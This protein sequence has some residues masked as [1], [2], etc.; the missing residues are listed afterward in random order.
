MESLEK[1]DLYKNTNVLIS[2]LSRTTPCWFAAIVSG[3]RFKYPLHLRML[4][5]VLIDASQR[6]IKKIII[7]M[8]PRHGKS[9]LISKY[10]PVW[11]LGTFPN[12]RIILASY[13]ATFAA[14]WGRKIRNIIK[15]HGEHYFGIKLDPK[16]S[17]TMRFDLSEYEGG[18]NTAGTG[19]PITGKGADLLI[20]DDPVKNDAEANSQ[21]LRDNLWDWFNTTAYT[22]LEPDGIIIIVMTRWHEDDLCGRILQ[23]ESKHQD[24]DLDTDKWYVF[25][26]P[27]LAE[28]NDALK[29]LPGEPL[30]RE[31]FSAKK[32]K[33]IKNTQG[34]YWF[35]AMYQQRPVPRGD[36]IF[37]RKYFRYFR[38]DEEFY[39]TSNSIG[40]VQHEKVIKR[41][42]CTIYSIIDLACSTKETA[43]YT[44]IL[45]C[46]VSPDN[47]V[48]IIDVIRERFSGADH[49]N[50]INKV[51]ER[52]HPVMIGIESN[53]FQITIIQNA[54]DSGYNVQELIADKDKLTRAL[55]MAARLEAGTVYF[56]AD[57]HWLDDFEAELLAFPNGRHDD[58]VDA[59]AY[60]A[61]F[62]QIKSGILPA[63]AGVS[64]TMK[65]SI[66]SGF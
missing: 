64:R 39:Y 31:R 19:G 27:A 14:S 55:P 48:F 29:R 24:D 11:Y 7:N 59:F 33:D 37:K 25:S 63:G 4:D 13:E 17:A 20:I 12:H 34:S 52:F 53:Q 60:I 57:A 61:V 42:D 50:Q 41:S 40:T 62:I 36:G 38:Q 2:A 30:W 9:E 1:T 46:A 26:L 44:V 10:F 54:R 8:P 47:N 18:L 35:S 43:D 23:N 65:N 5:K 6:K 56:L 49:L 51:N 58:Q 28:E 22:R 3:G 32:L 45:T 16:S 21:T 66:T 15:E